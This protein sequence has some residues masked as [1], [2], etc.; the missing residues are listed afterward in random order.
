MMDSCT[1]KKPPHWVPCA[2]KVNDSVHMTGVLAAYG[3]ASR[4]GAWQVCVSQEDASKYIE[5]RFVAGI[6]EM[7][8]VEE[9]EYAAI[10]E[11]ADVWL[12]E[13]AADCGAAY[14]AAMGVKQ[15]A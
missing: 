8:Q 6:R 4:F 12:A 15:P 2:V 11:R 10:R 9:Q 1:K 7:T 14:W 13:N 3:R 5:L